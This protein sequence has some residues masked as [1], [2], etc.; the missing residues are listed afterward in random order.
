MSSTPLPPFNTASTSTRR[1]PAASPRGWQVIACD[2][3]GTLLDRHHQCN[4]RDLDAL[5]R[6]LAAGL[7]VAICTG[8]NSLESAG[9]VA[10]LHLTGPGVFVNGAVIADMATGCSLAR[11][12][13]DPPLVDELINFFGRLGHAVLVLADD[14]DT[15]LPV[16]IRTQHGPPHRATVEW[17]IAN[18]MHALVQDQL[19]PRHRTRV[20]RA[21]IVVDVPEAVAIER[22]IAGHFGDRIF[23][24][25]IFSPIYECQV[26]DVFNPH[27]TKWT[28][29]QAVCRHLGV[30]PRHAV[31]VGD[32]VNDLPMLQNASLSF[33]MATASPTVQKAARHVTKS[34]SESGVADV[35][36]GILAGRY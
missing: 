2:L 8:R 34:Q 18:R 10:A 12:T 33:A 21:G 31:A 14:P 29:I 16:Y 20:V 1:P 6:A 9:L 4:A 27:A 32:D 22:A 35:I 13:L 23:S 3:D 11:T 7:H 24:Y 28:G 5:H 17:L 19:D 36:D 26:I 15:R 30:D 25:S